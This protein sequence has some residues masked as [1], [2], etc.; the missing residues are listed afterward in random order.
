[1]LLLG[2]KKPFLKD[3]HYFLSDV[4]RR[5][6]QPPAKNDVIVKLR[7]LVEAFLDDKLFTSLNFMTD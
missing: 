3:E 1:M 7:G 2:H 6:R 5:L 4:M